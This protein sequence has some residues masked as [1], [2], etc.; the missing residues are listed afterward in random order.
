MKEKVSSIMTTDVV[1]ISQDET[2]DQA[3]EYF[4][5][6]K[7]NHH[8]PVVEE[9]KLVGI[10]STTDLLKLNKPFEEYTSIKVKEIMTTKVG[11]L[12][13]DDQIGT[14]AEIFLHNFFHA[15][16][17]VDENRILLGIVSL[18]DVLK[19]QHDKHYPAFGQ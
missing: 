9:G 11:T 3:K 17:I 16:P 13:P 4:F 19:H 10:I 7:M 15:I 5:Q 2:L 18:V 8:L 12:S 14:A 6:H 1:T